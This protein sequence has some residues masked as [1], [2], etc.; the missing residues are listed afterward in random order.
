MDIK[1]R[2]SFYLQKVY[3]SN[4]EEAQ[5]RM[6]IR[7]DG[8]TLQFNAG[9]TINPDK[10]DSKNGR[11]SRNASNKKG[12]SA[13]D[14][15]QEIS[16]LEKVVEE[17]FK[18]FEVANKMPTDSEFKTAFNKA[19]GK[20]KGAYAD[21]TIQ[22]YINDFI[23]E[24]GTLNGWTDAT[25]YKFLALSKNLNKFNPKLGINDFTE[26]NITLFIDY[27]KEERQNTT[28]LK[29]WRLLTWFLR[30]CEKKQ[31]I[32][33]LDFKNFSPNLKVVSNKTVIFL[34]WDE[35]MDLYAF[36]FPQDKAHLE[37]VRDV[38][39]FQCFTS[40]RY[41]DVANLKR[42]NIQ[43]DHV[44]L[45]STKTNDSLIIELNKYS[46]AILEK[47]KDEEFKNNL[48]L[49]V[50]SNQKMNKWIKDCCCLIGMNTPTPTTYYQG[51]ERF[52]EV[53]PKYEL[54][55]THSARRTFI[56]NALIMGIP[57]STVMEWTGHS[58]YKAM[59]PYI[60]VADGEKKKQMAKFD[61][62]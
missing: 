59:K 18:A 56:C 17:I 29:M 13:F 28:I 42:E 53:K 15:N 51:S 44:R 20:S 50:I 27:L 47:Y 39:C 25:K 46:K 14:I 3:S 37:R 48:A 1:R 57:A 22:V 31:F 49:P 40:L 11:V 62:K 2:V 21:K 30:W 4:S 8:K 10:W 58:D 23:F 12:Y 9:F 34:T 24:Q 36:T 7:Y 61:E 54:I 35:L 41:S 55:G 26:K 6:R 52:D 38:F 45:V 16:K 60:G 33:C 43:G 5:I 32:T 19:I